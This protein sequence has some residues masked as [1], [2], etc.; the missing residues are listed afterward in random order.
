MSANSLNDVVVDSDLVRR[1]SSDIWAGLVQLEGKYGLD[2]TLI[3]LLIV[4][5]F[6]LRGRG[7]GLDPDAPLRLQLPWLFDGYEYKMQVE[8]K[9]N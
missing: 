6:V 4:A 1:I 3:S 7:V 8:S 5:G 9:G 2:P